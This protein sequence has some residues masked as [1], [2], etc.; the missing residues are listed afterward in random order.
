VA[1]EAADLA[2]FLLVAL[3][4]AGVPLADVAAELDRRALRLTRRPGE[5]KEET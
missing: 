3:A 2:Y 4:R 5:A 1:Q